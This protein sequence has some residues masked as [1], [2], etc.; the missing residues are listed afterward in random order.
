[1]EQDSREQHGEILRLK[2]DQQNAIRAAL[3]EKEEEVCHDSLGFRHEGKWL[4]DRGFFFNWKIS[5]IRQQHKRELQ[6]MI[7]EI[8]GSTNEVCSNDLLKQVQS[9]EII[10]A[11]LKVILH[12][13]QSKQK[14]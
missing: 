8:C 9:Q 13:F 7:N 11:Q 14:F 4:I 5:L 12:W 3:R 2:D 1:M 10:I 6:T